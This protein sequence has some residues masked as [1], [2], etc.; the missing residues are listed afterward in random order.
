MSDRSTHVEQARNLLDAAHKGTITETS[1]LNIVEAQVHATLAV[2]EQQR[3]ANI[4][5]FVATGSQPSPAVIA[6]VKSGLGLA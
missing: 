6:H 1:R 2:A 5:A 3:L 4:I